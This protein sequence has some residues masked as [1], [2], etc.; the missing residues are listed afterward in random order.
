LFDI[1]SRSIT[2]TEFKQIFLERKE[3]YLPSRHVSIF[4]DLLKN[5]GFVVNGIFDLS[6]NLYLVSNYLRLLLKMK[7]YLRS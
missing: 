5:E 2:E 3:L 7:N 4:W 1:Y 6:T